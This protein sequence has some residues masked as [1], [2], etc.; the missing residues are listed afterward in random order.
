MKGVASPDTTMGDI[1]RSAIPFLIFD[2]I[3]M[4][5]IIAFPEITLALPNLMGK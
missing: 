2:L 5:L 1:I 4:G 3:A